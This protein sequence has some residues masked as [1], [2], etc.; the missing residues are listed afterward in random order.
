MRA[1]ATALALLA[2]LGAGTAWA[3]GFDPA[4]QA[5]LLNRPLSSAD[6]AFCGGKAQ[7][8]QAACK[9]TRNYLVD[10]ANKAEKGFPPLA[11]I[12]FVKNADEEHQIEDRL[13]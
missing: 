9:V 8:Q 11:D 7:A 3:Q 12:A 2:A 5:A 6:Q 4:Y 13:P 1:A 10:I